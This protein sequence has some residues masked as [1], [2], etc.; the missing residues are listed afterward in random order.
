MTHCDCPLNGPC[1]D[2][3]F[4]GHRAN[5]CAGRALPEEKAK[6]YRA[7]WRKLAEQVTGHA[8]GGV[9]TELAALLAAMGYQ[10]S[11]KC[12]CKRR[13]AKMNRSGADWC[14][15]NREKIVGWLRDEARQ[16]N[17]TF[18]EAGARFLLWLAIRR[19]RRKAKANALAP[20][21]GSVVMAEG[22]AELH[23]A[24]S[25]GGVADQQKQN[26]E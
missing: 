24:E 22:I 14:E 5:I 3:G 19:A 10:E 8:A 7:N 20:G 4:S 17:V 1:R 18:V 26:H 16:Q 23:A 9:G 21:F 25:R 2:F 6:V 11:A 12:E 15:A 13:I